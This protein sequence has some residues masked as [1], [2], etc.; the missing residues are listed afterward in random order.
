MNSLNQLL[1]NTA[2]AEF[3]YNAGVHIAILSLIG[4]ALVSLSKKASAPLRSAISLASLAALIIPL[5][6]SAYHLIPNQADS[7]ALFPAAYEYTLPS[8]LELDPLVAHELDL[9]SQAN[10][11]TSKS[12]LTHGEQPQN[13]KVNPVP[14]TEIRKP[15]WF[16][17]LTLPQLLN[18]F[19]LIW[20][21][22][23]I[24][25]LIQLAYGLAFL[26]GFRSGL[27]LLSDNRILNILDQ[28]KDVYGDKLTPRVFTSPTIISPTTI[29]IKSPNVILP[30][31]LYQNMNDDE[32][33]SVLFHELAHIYHRDHL[34]GLFQ[35]VIIALNWWNP[36][37]YKIS[38]GFSIAREDVSDN[39]AIRELHSPKVYAES[40]INLAEKTSLISNMPA[41]VGMAGKH[42]PM[43]QRIRNILS[44]ER[45]MLLK[46]S[47]IMK[48]VL[49]VGLCVAALVVTSMQGSF[50]HT[51]QDQSHQYTRGKV[52]IIKDDILKD[53]LGS[54][55]PFPKNL[56]PKHTREAIIKT[57]MAGCRELG[58]SGNV[59]M[60]EDSE[61]PP[62]I[63]GTIDKTFKGGGGFA[64]RLAETKAFRDGGLVHGGGTSASINNPNNL[65]ITQFATNFVPIMKYKDLPDNT[66][67]RLMLRCRKMY[68]LNKQNDSF[69]QGKNMHYGS[70]KEFTEDE[71]L[72]NRAGVPGFYIYGQKGIALESAFTRARKG[73]KGSHTTYQTPSFSKDAY[74]HLMKLSLKNDVI[75]MLFTKNT[76]WTKMHESFINILPMDMEEIKTRLNKNE[77]IQARG[78]Y[79]TR[80]VVILAAPNEKIL[81]SMV[82]GSNYFELLHSY[83]PES[84][85]NEM[86]SLPTRVLHIDRKDYDDSNNLTTLDFDIY[87]NTDLSKKDLKSELFRE[88]FKKLEPIIRNGSTHEKFT[89]IHKLGKAFE[90]YGDKRS[91]L[92][93]IDASKQTSANKTMMKIKNLGSSTG[94]Y[95]K[96]IEYYKSNLLASNNDNINRE[97]FNLTIKHL[98]G[99]HFKIGGTYYKSGRL[100][101]KAPIPEKLTYSEKKKYGAT[102][103]ERAWALENNAIAYHEKVLQTAKNENHPK[104]WIDKTIE[105]IKEIKKYHIAIRHI[106]K[107]PVFI[108]FSNSYPSH[109][110][111]RYR[112]SK[113]K[114]NPDYLPLLS[115]KRQITKY[116]E[117]RDNLLFKV[118]HEVTTVFLLINDKNSR[119]FKSPL[120][121]D[122][123]PLPWSEIQAHFDKGKSI[124]KMKMVDGIKI[125]LLAAEDEEKIDHLIQTTSL[126][127]VD[128][129]TLSKSTV[130]KYIKNAIAPSQSLI[131]S[132]SPNPMHGRVK[133]KFTG[134]NK[135]ANSVMIF[136]TSGK[137]INSYVNPSS[138]V[139]TWNATDLP[140]AIYYAQVKSGK[141]TETVKLVLGK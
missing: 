94:F 50:A 102:L 129:N 132:F 34:V 22:G 119:F 95:N 9:Q 109:D 65:N 60:V 126:L 91:D 56:N 36:L 79:N 45:D 84:P 6:I 25:V 127:N 20:I 131:T 113:R 104:E 67:E 3:I 123:L 78:R 39:Y 130:N 71:F 115:A 33:R 72:K 49:P 53:N 100:Y 98:Y 59:I 64:R 42:L 14:P 96:A 24:Y 83:F 70:I 57:F 35:R 44:K 38:A 80:N 13:E 32:I 69:A 10:E 103:N 76:N 19:G 88:L 27:A 54:P 8:T 40:L 137:L 87:E 135:S 23:T 122:L 107:K 47:S 55:I 1:N 112:I 138:D 121:K 16:N 37:V 4:L 140:P 85:L 30:L 26:K 108:G 61:F 73:I 86:N 48:T 43:E 101:R 117:M 2:S 114:P 66:I 111:L 63:V 120:F 62:V 41:T 68:R 110:A 128:S 97:W 136:D 141:K 46:I 52:K 11:S 58:A 134:N 139:I 31:H 133:I 118:P 124:E 17:S 92:R 116:Y 18:A 5:G 74:D 29:G 28:V 105:A 7:Q 82:K 93:N 15:S 77:T 75:L 51:E 81:D 99:C 21:L 125:I 89:A 12:S 106:D 90:D